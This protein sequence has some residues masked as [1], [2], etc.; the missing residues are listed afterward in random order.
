MSFATILDTLTTIIW[1]PALVFV[2]LAVGIFFTISTLFM[3]IRC[4][5]DMFQQMVGNDDSE[6]GVSSFKALMISLAGRVGVGN[7]AGVA[8]AI[9]YGGPGA[10]FWMWIVAIFGAAT[11]F[12]ECTLAQ[13]YKEKDQDTGEYRG[14]PAYYIEKAF[15]HTRARKFMLV[16]AIIFAVCMVLSGGYFLL[17]IQANGVADAMRN[18]WGINVW[19][20]AAVSAVLVGVIIMGG[21]KRIANF[22]SLVV[23][24]MAI[25]YILAAVIIMFVNFHHIDDVFSLIFRSAFDREAMFSGM[26]GSAIMWGV[27][28]GIYSN[29]AGQGTGPQSAAAAEVSHP[30]KQGFVQAFAVYAGT[31]FVCSATAF[32]ILST[33]MYKV[34]EGESQDGPE[35]YAGQL[36]DGVDVGPGFVQE[37][38]NSFV[39]GIGAGF[40]ALAIVL[41]AFTT[42][43]AY[44]YMAETNLAYFNRWI[45]NHKVRVSLLIG[46]RVLA[47]ASVVIGATTTPGNAWAL[48]DIGVGVTTWLN[49]IAITIVQI[50]AHKAL[51]DYQRQKKAGLDPVFEPEKLGIKNADFWTV[52]AMEERIAAKRA[53]GDS[54][55]KDEIDG[56]PNPQ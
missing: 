50:P 34:F 33:D 7:I 20:S 25:I 38:L 19:L 8:T 24:F 29:E 35:R 16:Y 55:S 31:L 15:Q 47:V 46:L 37:G 45:P 27:K 52:R 49:I 5:P 44:Y 13:I 21:V 51:W 39:P 41:F 14:G 18:A 36:A 23:P 40:V 30:A 2:C 43:L 56:K 9:A 4:I 54:D 26:L 12:M 1:S 17:G 6:S 53:A 3:Q 10:V 42:V 11:S 28:R 22:A 48:G 32:I